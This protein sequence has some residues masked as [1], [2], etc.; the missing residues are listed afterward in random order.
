MCTS[1]LSEAIKDNTQTI[2]GSTQAIKSDAQT[3]KSDLNSVRT[4]GDNAEH[5]QLLEWI[6]STDYPAQ[7][8]DIIKRRQ[9]GTGEWFL[10]APQV[11]TWL[12]EPQATLFCPRIP[13][14]GK[15]MIAAIAIDY[16]LKSLQ[17]S[18]HGVAYVYCNYKAQE[19]QDTSR[20][21]AAILKQLVQA[22]PLLAQP[23]QRLHEQ[24][25]NRGTR[26]SPDEIFSAVQDV[27][28][29]Y[30]AIYIVVDT[31]NEFRDSNGARRQFLDKLR[32]LQQGRDVRLMATSR[33]IPEIVDAFNEDLKLEV[34][35][36][37]ED[38]KRFVAGQIYRLPRCIQRDPELR[39]IVQKK[40][41]EAVDGMYGLPSQL[42]L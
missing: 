7:Q 40:I 21:L 15:T 29:H 37:V 39:E 9:D 24:H 17:N 36:S 34:Q 26:P 32:H 23:I 16:L 10:A 22:R 12:S 31:L 13:G 30:S 35:A 38:V 4:H 14:A 11:A 19:E 5:R 1:T 18:S 25:A 2:K 33:F 28:S 42:L 20:M 27:I 3:I 6:S 8:S 41:V